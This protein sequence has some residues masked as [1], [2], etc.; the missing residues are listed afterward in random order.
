MHLPEGNDAPTF[1]GAP[2]DSFSALVKIRHDQIEKKKT[3]TNYN[4]KNTFCLYN[5]TNNKLSKSTLT[6]MVLKG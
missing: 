6:F 5:N 1:S 4:Y 3:K 2:S